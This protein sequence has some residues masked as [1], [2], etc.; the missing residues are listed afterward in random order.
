MAHN[1][2]ISEVGM[3]ALIDVIVGAA[4]ADA[5][6]LNQHFPFAA[7]GFRPLL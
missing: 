4:D 6:D 7:A 2:R 1:P 3:R 5:S